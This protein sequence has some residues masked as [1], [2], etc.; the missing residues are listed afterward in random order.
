MTNKNIVIIGCQAFNLTARLQVCLSSDGVIE[1]P[2][3]ET[4]SLFLS[5]NGVTELPNKKKSEIYLYLLMV[6]KNC[7]RK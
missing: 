3:K 5:P 1:L 6:C 4:R 7:L 2:E